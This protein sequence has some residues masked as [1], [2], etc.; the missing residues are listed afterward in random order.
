MCGI[1]GQLSFGAPAPEKAA[2]RAMA[3]TLAHRG[4]DGQGLYLDGH[5]GLGHRRLSIIDLAT[6]DQPMST[7][8]GRRHIV[9]NGEL[10]NY[11]ALRTELERRG[12][13]FRTTSDTEV[14]LQ[15]LAAWGPE[16]LARFNGIFALALWDARER[17]LLLARDH[18][19]IKPLYYVLASGRLVFGSEPKAIFASGL[20]QKAVNT[21]ALFEF[22]C[23][24]T[25]PCPQTMFKDVLEV[26]PGQWM[27]FGPDGA[28]RRGRHYVLEEAWAS[29]DPADIPAD[30]AGLVR[31]VTERIDACVTGQLVSDVP[32]GLSLSSGLDSGVLLHFMR[33]AFASDELHAF[34]YSNRGGGQDEAVGA[35]RLA[36]GFAGRLEHHILPVGL[37]DYHRDFAEACRFLD[38]PMIYP[39]SAPIL[40]LSRL[41]RDAGVKVLM[42]GQGADELF[43]GYVRYGRW[44]ETLGGSA[45]RDAWTRH[46]YFGGGIDKIDIVERMTRTDR[47][48]AADSQAWRWVSEH[49]DLPPMA[50]MALYDQR[51]RLLYLLKRDDRMGMGGSV[52]IRVPFL[53]KEFMTWANAVPG[54]WKIRDGRQKF[55][56]GRMAEGLLPQDVARGPKIGSPTVFEAW[57]DSPAFLETLGAMVRAEGSFTRSY[58]DADEAAAQLIEHGRNGNRGF[59]AWALYTIEQWH[60]TEFA[61][62][63]RA[64]LRHDTEVL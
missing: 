25:P 43:M 17:R 59:L 60:E 54:Q 47:D 31:A 12:V 4:P 10:Y 15:A 55:L 40:G 63:Q 21:G 27:E 57:L 26:E 5:C 6:G 46:F 1:C 64:P 33:G 50:R 3:D 9:Y 61:D 52:E 45:D 30:E 44:L 20:V 58:L 35:A 29:V 16:A 2:L 19:G 28:V 39:S 24:M 11:L 49:W 32:L 41:A 14:V 18:L 51:F 36:E 56:L 37:D 34:T 23:R 7:A 62:P 38:A 42:S 53:D 48:A 22:F 13:A 8:D